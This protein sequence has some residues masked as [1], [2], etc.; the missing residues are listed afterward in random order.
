MVVENSLD[1]ILIVSLTGV[2]LF[3]N[4]ALANIFDIGRESHLSGTRNVMEFIAPES[5]ARVLHDFGQVAQGI[6]SYPMNYQAITVTGR[7][8]G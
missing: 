6:D 3:R 7:D 4:Q 2:V 1:G 5:R 8:L